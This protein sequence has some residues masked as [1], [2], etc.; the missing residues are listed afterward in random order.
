MQKTI[1]RLKCKDPLITDCYIGQTKD[2]KE[3]KWH[4]T[5]DCNNPKSFKY[6]FKVYKFIRENGGWDNW[7]MNPLEVIFCETEKEARKKELEF[8]IKFNATL[9]TQKPIRDRKQWLIDNKEKIKQKRRD[10]YEKIKSLSKT[11]QCS[12]EKQPINQ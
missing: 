11:N 12:Q 8:C 2:F 4:H 9:N 6:N 7:Q 10:Y 5:G 1:Y 3:R